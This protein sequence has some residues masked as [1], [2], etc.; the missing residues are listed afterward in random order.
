MCKVLKVGSLILTVVM[1]CQLFAS[2]PLCAEGL[3]GDLNSD[4]SVNSIDFA[5]LRGYLVGTSN[6]SQGTD[7]EKYADIYQD[8]SINSLDFAILRRY[9]LGM[10]KVLP[11]IPGTSNVTPSPTPTISSSPTPQEEWIPY[12]PQPEDVALSLV[13]DC[14]SGSYLNAKR[15]IQ[16]NITFPD[17]G[18]RIADEGQLVSS[19]S[20]SSQFNYTT[21]GVKIEKYVGPNPVTHALM[22][23][24]IK[25]QLDDT[26]SKRNYFNFIV[27]D[28]S[29]TEFYFTSDSVIAPTPVPFGATVNKNFVDGNTKFAADL[30]KKFS[31][32]DSCKNVFFS[33]FSISM[34]LSM[35]YQ[36]AGT[37]TK[38]SIAKALNYTGMSNEEINQSYIDHLKYFKNLY[39]QVE[40]N[41]ANSIWLREGFEAKES[42]I[43]KNQEVFNAQCSY[44]DFSD[45]S[46]CDVMNKWISD[47]TKGKISNMVE[48]PI[49]AETVMNLINAIY[50]KGNW[51]DQFDISQTT[52][53]TFTNIN[54]KKETVQMMHKF[55]DYNYAENDEFRAIELPY[56]SGSISM[57]CILPEASNVND[58][59]AEFDNNK[60]TEIKS[61]LSHGSDI[62]LSIPRFKF[63]YK[64]QNVKQKLADLGMGEAF[65]R[66]ADFSG[67]G[68]NVWIDS[69][70]HKAVIDINEKGAEAAAVTI[71]GLFGSGM[72]NSFIA[73]K[74]FM[75]IIA[76]N[77]TGTILF[78]G[79]VVDF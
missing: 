76:D 35:V 60:W 51:T 48:P 22:S 23:K 41:V 79:K 77:V 18:Y 45:P 2:I 11:F 55:D 30:F 13:I 61:K 10:T 69:V 28:T 42:F 78:M 4:G 27:Y 25:Y 43:S 7:W 62:N 26:L 32:E 5:L 70:T 9:L 1:L 39:P 72:P 44:L 74:P 29:V 6:G 3:Y 47:A 53:G 21:S 16:A 64:P 67:I 65:S 58:F 31:E 36:G 57:Y 46:S 50:F 66:N 38:D 17:G 59:I 34:A 71:I 54:G 52:E 33:P 40:L 63:E 75:F 19:T 14:S 56:G 73:D 20:D 37:T 15:Y 24:Q 49:P 8:N 12:I 68:E